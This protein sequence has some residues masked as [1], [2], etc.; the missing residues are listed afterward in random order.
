MSNIIELTA[1]ITNL[2]S[3]QCQARL[4]SG[5]QCP[6]IIEP[7]LY[8]RGKHNWCF[9]VTHLDGDFEHHIEE[10]GDYCEEED[11]EQITE[12][13]NAYCSSCFEVFSD[14]CYAKKWRESFEF[15]GTF[16]IGEQQ[17]EEAIYVDADGCAMN[18]QMLYLLPNGVDM[19][20]QTQNR[21]MSDV[22]EA[23]EMPQL[24]QINL[25]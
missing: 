6:N 22:G 23:P 4:P 18:T 20:V 19:M 15:E 9:H 11:C 17:V 5:I 1:F 13:N 12:Y 24:P 8:C 2:H 3:N 10:H 21:F 16:I 25:F 14:L 7:F